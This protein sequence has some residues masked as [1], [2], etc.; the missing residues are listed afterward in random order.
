MALSVVRGVSKGGVLMSRR[1]EEKQLRKAAEGG[2]I[3][4][5]F[6]LADMLED[7]GDPA[8]AERWYRFA[9]T[10]G[11]LK[12]AFGL[13][14]ILCMRGAFE[15]AEPWLRKVTTSDD[16]RLAQAGATTLGMCLCDLDRFDEAEQWLTI[17]ADAGDAM[18]VKY[19]DKLRK[20]RAGGDVLQTFEVDGVMFYDGSGHR[21][22]PSVCTL[23]RT[24]LII[25][26][27][28]GGISQIQLRD[29]HGVSTPGRIVSPK[30]LRITAGRVGYDIYCVSK[31]QKYQL[32]AWLSKAIRGA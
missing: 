24:R 20:D 27:A 21:L 11:H 16:P 10:R 15:E 5:A 6:E 9:A 14:T 8:G 7:D 23:T 12:S 19:L 17:G 31:D 4:A 3:D 22:G 29:I 13:G 18:A 2:D 26:D 1:S 25:D 32:E 30:M 28:R